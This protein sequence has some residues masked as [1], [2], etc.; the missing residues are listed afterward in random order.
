MSKLLINEHPLQVLPGLATAIGL[1]EAILLQ[2]IH[3]WLQTSKHHL[4][5]RRW[6]YNSVPKWQEQFPFWSE[7]TIRRTLNSLRKQQLIDVTDQYNKMPMDKTLWYTINY[8]AL[9]RVTIPS[10]QNDHT[11]RSKWIDDVVNLDRAIPETT[12][13]TNSESVVNVNVFQEYEKRWGIAP[14][15]TLLSLQ[16]YLELNFEPQ[17]IV[18]VMEI[19][20][21]KSKR[22]NYAAGILDNLE[23]EHNITTLAAYQELSKRPKTQK[24]RASIEELAN[25]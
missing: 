7:S 24:N 5:G 16:K 6:I 13:E 22:W 15:A 20:Q 18:E 10:G 4:D 11:I 23:H 12:T 19:A 8:E 1:N 21:K 14:N 9:N 3:Y 25:F 2:Q 17:L